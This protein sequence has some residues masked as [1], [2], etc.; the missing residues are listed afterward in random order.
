MCALKAT[1]T[2]LAK[3]LEVSR[4]SLYY[5]PKKPSSDDALRARIAAVMAEHRAYGH[6]RIA[7]ALRMNRKPV[8]RVM[9]I[10]GMRPAVRRGRRFTK[11]GDLGNAEIPM[12]NVLKTLCPLYPGIVWAGDFTYFFLGGRFWYVATVIDVRTREILG[13]ETSDHHTA[14][15]VMDA[16][17]DAVR[18][19]GRAP[20]WFHSDQGSEYASEAFG[21]MLAAY[22]TQQSMSR[23]SSPWQNGFQESFYAMFKLEIGDIRRFAHV[24]ELIE[25]AAGQIAYYNTVRIHSALKM[26]PMA[27]RERTEQKMAAL[28]A[29]QPTVC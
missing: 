6:R 8:I 15:L 21:K 4:S 2:A 14:G 11:P 24:G 18:R 16:F 23:K 10:F 25:A 27:Y 1:R 9:N 29:P 13:W 20:T 12:P 26:P 22:G 19:T 5:K 28:A 3:K 17:R 7:I